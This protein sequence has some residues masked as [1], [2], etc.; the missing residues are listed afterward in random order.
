LVSGI[1]LLYARAGSDL[2]SAPTGTDDEQPATE[3][4]DF[5]RI[6]LPAI[7]Y[8][9]GDSDATH[10]SAF[11]LF[12]L[13]ELLEGALWWILI[14]SCFSFFFPTLRRSFSSTKN[15]LD[16]FNFLTSLYLSTEICTVP[17][18]QAATPNPARDHQVPLP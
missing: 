1:C 6:L 11:F 15:R 14:D 13:C 7:A 17:L 16:F 3:H 18:L 8:P 4:K 10:G 5:S 2:R 12:F 9:N